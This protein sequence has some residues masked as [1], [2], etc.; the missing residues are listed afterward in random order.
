[1]NGQTGQLRVHGHFNGLK[2]TLLFGLMWAI[3]MLIWWTTGGSRGTL[4]VY[5]VI[6]LA[7]TFLS[8]WFSDRIAI[9]SMGAR[10][11]SEAEAPELYCIVRE[12]SARAGRPMPRIYVAPTM[13]P[14]AFATGRNEN[15]A[16]VCCTQGILR[17]L[18]ER[19][20][21]GVLGHELMH[22]YN[23][24]ILT[25]AVASAMATVITYL[26]Y[27]LMYLGNGRDDRNNGGGLGL[28]GVL[29]SSILAPLGASLIQLAISRTREFDADEDGSMLTGDPMAL[30][31]AL[32]RIETGINAEPMRQT[33]GTQSASAMMIANPFR[34]DG[35]S[36][37]FSTH[38]P[39]SERIARLMQM[40]QEMAAAQLQGG[41]AG[42]Q[43]PY[44]QP[45]YSQYAR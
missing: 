1:M 2:T 41:P 14:N 35:F 12:L 31:S 9:A 7:T 18:N 16:A 33:A 10:E 22:V 24:D 17:I 13:S 40:S 3:I 21:R 20:L 11:V 19:E 34:G 45:S 4:G 23:H 43:Q 29:V 37:L 25:S 39:T 28:I 32:N 42:V 6:G 8:Y 26:G 27:S 15:H 30:A 38:P 5:I 44:V 36:R